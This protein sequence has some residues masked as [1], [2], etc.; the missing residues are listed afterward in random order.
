MLKI[1]TLQ[2]GSILKILIRAAR[3]CLQIL[4][5]RLPR[6]ELASPSSGNLKRRML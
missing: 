6:G 5:E 3:M 2:R 4:V 1:E